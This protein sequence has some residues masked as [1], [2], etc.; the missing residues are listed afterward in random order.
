MSEYTDFLADYDGEKFAIAADLV[1]TRIKVL[2]DAYDLLKFLVTSDEELTLDEKSAKKNL[3]EDAVEPLEAG[4]T[5]IEA[6]KEWST[7]NIEAALTKALIEDLGLKPR[8]A[9]G[10]L[11]VAISGAAISPPLFESMDLLGKES[12]L[13]RL[14]AARAVTPF[15]AAEQPAQ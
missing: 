3:K 10:A 2:S 14:N 7:P 12:T 15:Q 11:R 13:A 9:Y 1:Q 8:K 6:V 5:A 4:I